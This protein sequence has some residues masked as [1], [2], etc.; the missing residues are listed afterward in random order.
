MS[1]FA[2]LFFGFFL[3]FVLLLRK[4]I[5]EVI[6]EY[7]KTYL[8]LAMVVL[9]LMI[10][11]LA[12]VNR[13]YQKYVYLNGFVAPIVPWLGVVICII[14]GVVLSIKQKSYTDLIIETLSF[15]T[16]FSQMIFDMQ[17]WYEK[18]KDDSPFFLRNDD[19]LKRYDKAM[20]DFIELDLADNLIISQ[21]KLQTLT[22][23]QK[24]L[25]VNTIIGHFV[26]AFLISF[27]L[28]LPVVIGYYLVTGT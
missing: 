21:D 14:F 23:I 11:V 5:R 17:C 13:I 3:L 22:V 26:V 4:G 6:D 16:R 10:Q 27:F 20:W 15:D 9:V 1:V 24:K 7:K 28:M 8:R 18:H 19:E 25:R 2:I 12:V